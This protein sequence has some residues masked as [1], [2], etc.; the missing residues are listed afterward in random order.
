MTRLFIA[1]FFLFLALLASRP[2]GA[3]AALDLRGYSDES[4]AI[5]VL[6]HGDSVDPYF[7]MQSLLLAHEY[8]M[9]IEAPAERFVEWLLPRQK[10]DGT[11]DRFCQSGRAKW[12]PCKT[13]DA[14]DS[15]LAMWIKLLETMPAS[16][17]RKAAWQR[18]HAA[19][20]KALEHLFQPSTGIYMVSPLVLHGLF[21]DNL[22]VWHTKVQSKRPEEVAEA[23]KLAR[24]IHQTFWN[25]VDR[26]FLVSTQLE[27]RKA[28]PAFYPDHIAQIFPLLVGFP[29]LPTEELPHYRNWMREHRTA[30]LAQGDADY[31]WGVIALIALR[32][33]D[34][35]SA[36]CW[37]AESAARRHSSR[38]AV[39]DETA[40]Q[41]LSSRGLKAA[42][43]GINCRA[44][45]RY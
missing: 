20:R 10:P 41:I 18:S 22:E 44:V 30:W 15:L 19:S 3:A 43:P 26:R 34:R 36:S 24:A 7:A 23:A 45:P 16:L 2:A 13:A 5:S 4:G 42:Q 39:S 17:A 1:F 38:W 27:Q 33:G 14:D 6:Q 35:D 31:P 11:F 29:L 21:L 40:L 28:K 32:Q 37:L 9:N 25:P 12:L 8:G